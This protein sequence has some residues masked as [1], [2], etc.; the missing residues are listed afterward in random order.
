MLSSVLRPACWRQ[1]WHDKFVCFSIWHTGSYIPRWF[2]LSHIA[3][4]YWIVWSLGFPGLPEP[5]LLNQGL[6][7]HSWLFAPRVVLCLCRLYR[8]TPY[9]FQTSNPVSQALTK[10]NP[11][12][13]WHSKKCPFTNGF[14]IPIYPWPLLIWAKS[15]LCWMWARNDMVFT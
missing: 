11:G 13:Q 2:S 7:R 1:K 8:I 3:L 15:T 6:A 4:C 14:Y 10:S 9:L 5:F 12:F